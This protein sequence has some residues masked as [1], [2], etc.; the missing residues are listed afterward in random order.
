[1]GGHDEKAFAEQADA[2]QEREGDE[3]RSVGGHPL[4]FPGTP[5][6]HPAFDVTPAALVSALVTERGVSQAR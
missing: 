4:T 6:R 1:M 2:G 3:V 5:T